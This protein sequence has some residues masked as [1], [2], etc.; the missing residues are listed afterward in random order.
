M[1]SC[2]PR[3]MRVARSRWP[4]DQ[5]RYARYQLNSAHGHM[6]EHVEHH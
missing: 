1:E 2:C 4:R 5:E 6:P 3:R